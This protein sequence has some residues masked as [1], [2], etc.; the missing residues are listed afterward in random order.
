MRKSISYV[1]SELISYRESSVAATKQFVKWKHNEILCP[2]LEAQLNR[3][4]DGFLKYSSVAYDVQG[5]RDQGTD[6]LLRYQS[7][8][9]NPDEDA[10]F[11]AFQVKGE[12]DLQQKDYLKTLRSQAFEALSEYGSSLERYYVVLCFD[13]RAYREQ[14]RAINKTLSL[15]PRI[16]VVNPRYALT[17]LRLSE[18]RIVSLVD[19]LLREEDEVFRSAKASIASM[20]PTQVAVLLAATYEAVFGY[21]GRDIQLRQVSSSTFVQRVFERCPD[22]SKDTWSNLEDIGFGEPD[23]E[24]ELDLTDYGRSYDERF[25]DDLDV[26]VD[27]GEFD[28]RR[29]EE[30][31]RV[32]MES[33]RPIQALLLDGNIRYGYQHDELLRFVF[34]LLGV[35]ETFG[36]EGLDE[37]EDPTIGS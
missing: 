23:D 33:V 28:L 32:N 10:C 13:A 20:P 7:E 26:L 15:D 22:F 17:F 4:R 16:V 12:W 37:V 9:A 21:G 34:G 29:G 11:M 8:D 27:L 35:M 31:V 1:V 18:S 36:A 24:D 3:I 19:G 6:V 5:P 30:T 25:A 14:I 2:R